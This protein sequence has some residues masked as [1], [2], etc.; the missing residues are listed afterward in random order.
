MQPL[1]ISLH[2]WDVMCQWW[3]IK[4]VRILLGESYDLAGKVRSVNIAKGNFRFAPVMYLEP[5]LKHISAMPQSTFDE[6][7]EKYT[8]PLTVQ[9]LHRPDR[10]LNRG[11]HNTTA[12]GNP[13]RLPQDVALMSACLIA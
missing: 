7:I 5:S 12:I 8:E 4:P 11:L 1:L 10:P 2:F 9:I 6:I 13:C 3:H